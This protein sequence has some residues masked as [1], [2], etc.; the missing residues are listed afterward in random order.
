MSDL[1]VIPVS[2]KSLLN[3]KI[4]SLSLWS[5]EASDVRCSE[6]PQISRDLKTF[7][8]RKAK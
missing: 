5:L 1:A 2:Y 8:N 4:A 6:V 3:K 7:F